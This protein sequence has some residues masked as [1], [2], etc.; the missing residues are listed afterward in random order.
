[1]QEMKLKWKKYLNNLNYYNKKRIFLNIKKTTSNKLK[2]V[3][4][5]YKNIN[6]KK[7]KFN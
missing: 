2:R 1:M 5:S 6:I 4:N 7:N 3:N